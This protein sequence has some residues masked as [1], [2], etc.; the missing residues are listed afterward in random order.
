MTRRDHD[1]GHVGDQLAEE[2][3]NTLNKRFPVRSH[4]KEALEAAASFL[5]GTIQALDEEDRR[6][7]WE[8]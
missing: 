3:E 7:E 6:R 1:P 4:F 2:L 5:Q 8:A